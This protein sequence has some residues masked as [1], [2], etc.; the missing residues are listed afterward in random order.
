[1]TT[2]FT[3]TPDEIDTFRVV[4]EEAA[5]GCSVHASEM[6]PENLTAARRLVELGY[7]SEEDNDFEIT[8]AGSAAFADCGR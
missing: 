6:R 1:M 5:Y 2:V 4:E 3:P 8:E 7:L